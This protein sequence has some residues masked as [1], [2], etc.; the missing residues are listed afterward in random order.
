MLWL[1]FLVDKDITIIEPGYR[2]KYIQNG[3]PIN[4]TEIVLLIIDYLSSGI[5]S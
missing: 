4:S 2:T 3:K 5:N 1:M